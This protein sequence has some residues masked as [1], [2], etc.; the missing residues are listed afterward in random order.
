MLIQYI[1]DIHI[2][3]YNNYRKIPKITPNSEILV[4]AGDI[5]YPSSSLYAEFLIDM[6]S[7]FKKIFLL[8]GNHEYYNLGK[9]KDNGMEK[10]NSKIKEIISYNKLNNI[11]F[12]DNSYEDYNGYRF[13]GC[14]LWSEIK[15]KMYLINDFQNIKDIN[16]E[17]YNELY[18]VNYEYL[19]EN[20]PNSPLP[21]IVITHHLPSYNLIDKKY[22]T[23]EILNYNQ[24]FASDCSKLFNEKIKLWIYGHTHTK[25]ISEIN[26]I[27]F[28][29]NP[30][31][32]PGENSTL[33]LNEVINI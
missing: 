1:S 31:G 18:K 11:T 24:C 30:L 27:K 6:N 22:K 29:S 14:T 21:L 10:I 9:N 26:K 8:A 25:N 12:L 7:K 5:G 17:L 19:E 23:F 32:Y 13:I 16:I 33:S 2:E 20:I 28:V 4:L 3:F 15:D